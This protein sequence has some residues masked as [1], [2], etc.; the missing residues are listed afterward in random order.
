MNSLQVHADVLDVVANAQEAHVGRLV[1]QLEIIS[2]NFTA[3]MLVRVWAC[4]MRI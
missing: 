4:S 3:C 2:V 1:G